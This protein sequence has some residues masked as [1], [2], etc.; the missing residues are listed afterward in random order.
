MNINIATNASPILAAELKRFIEYLFSQETLAIQH[1]DDKV[2]EATDYFCNGDYSMG[3]DEGRE[4]E[5]FEGTRQFI[6][7]MLQEFPL[8]KIDLP[9]GS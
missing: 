7:G 8:F 2:K 4:A 3:V 6:A 1:R 9:A 5:R